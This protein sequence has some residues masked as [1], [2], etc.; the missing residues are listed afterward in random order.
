M[1]I[2]EDAGSD[3]DEETLQLK[4]Q[5][6]EAKLKLR[7][8]R[9][10]KSK[11]QTE[12]PDSPRKESNT[13][14]AITALGSARYPK[15]H[16]P[17]NKR[18]RED[19]QVPLSPP[20]RK[21]VVQET[22]SPGRIRLGIDKGLTA[23][24]VS[25]RRPPVASTSS[26]RSP[27]KRPRTED[28]HPQQRGSLTKQDVSIEEDIKPKSFS[29]RIA[30]LRTH[31]RSRKD[32]Q[33]QIQKKR[34]KGFGIPAEELEEASKKMF[35]LVDEGDEDDDDE[36]PFLAEAK[37]SKPREFTREEVLQ[38]FNHQDGQVVK[39]SK[40]MGDLRGGMK[41]SEPS[42]A[43]D[44]GHS[45]RAPSDAPA[46][47]RKEPQQASSQ[48]IVETTDDSSSSSLEPF[49]GLHLSKR[50][51]PHALLRRTF[52]DKKTFHIPDLLKV[53]KSPTY[54]PPDIDQ[55]WVIFGIIA[56][57]S[58][59]R[60][61]QNQGGSSSNENNPNRG[62]YMVLTLTDLKWELDLFLFS[63]AFD[64]FWKLTPGSIIAILN[65]NIY[66]PPPTKRDTGKFS[67]TLTSSDDTILEIGVARDI[68][69]C[70]SVKKDGSICSSWVDKRHTEFC[71]FHV[72]VS[73]R[74]TKAKRMEVNT[75]SSNPF[76][77]GGKN[78]NGGR[79][80]G[81]NGRTEG[82]KGDEK[83]GGLKRDNQGMY[84]DRASHS[85]V[86]IAG[87]IPP[88]SSAGGY[89][90]GGRSS[91]ALLDDEDVDPDAFHRG[92]SKQER[93]RRQLATQEREREIAKALGK[94][95]KG[96]GGT[97]LRAA[98]TNSNTPAAS[99]GGGGGTT[100]KG[101]AGTSE[102]SANDR[103]P[104]TTKGKTNDGE[105]NT[106]SQEREE[107]RKPT[108]DLEKRRATYKAD[109]V[110]LSPLKKRRQNH[111]SSTTTT[112]TT[113]KD[114]SS[115]Q[116][117]VGVGWGGAYKRGLLLDEKTTTATSTKKPS[118]LERVGNAEEEM[119]KRTRT[120]GRVGGHDD[121]DDDD[122]DDGLEI[123]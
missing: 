30:E 82:P 33:D 107:E 65:P 3:E 39:R 54:D 105:P 91:A 75:M 98:T 85:Q 115:T 49:S 17:R 108:L 40:T 113:T 2:S 58:N 35:T 21:R 81:R 50:L 62:K 103:H 15:D 74:K 36:D 109:D 104:G 70:K 59:P 120:K 96:M 69:F 55:D 88:P 43:K 29:E 102:A 76:G 45:Y 27:H 18:A 31:D 114:A 10:A 123:I 90:F 80:G 97:Y 68:G 25:L 84:H 61:H 23:R 71:Q 72:D 37:R 53:V 101:G 6:I 12:A 83:D 16:L 51:L 66:P 24:D 73:V 78:G 118:L 112:T 64:R 11:S 20:D 79:G 5:A 63:T 44:S 19:V 111:I 32:R 110:R 52:S 14:P 117:K 60:T 47:P 92:Y 42:I 119:T 48:K 13:T 56:S 121:D 22:R 99:T 95:G 1:D 41:T 28:R 122:D 67:I 34:S 87:P 8:L 38:G 106:Q 26:I 86:F 116:H 4:L 9:Q 46:H 100:T 77:P 94:G 93:L 89:G 7:K 57:K